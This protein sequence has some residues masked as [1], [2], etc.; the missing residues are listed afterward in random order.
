MG[1]DIKGALTL[2]E[3]GT[4]AKKIKDNTL[5]ILGI[6]F[7]NKLYKMYNYIVYNEDGYDLIILVTR[8]SY[9]LYRIFAFLIETAAQTTDLKSIENN[10]SKIIN[11][12]QLNLL[13]EREYE[14][15][16]NSKVLVVDDILVRGNSIDW[17]LKILQDNGVTSCADVMVYLWDDN[18]NPK[19]LPRECGKLHYYLKQSSNV[20]VEVSSKLIKIILSTIVPYSSYIHG[21][22]RFNKT[23]SEG[24]EEVE[25]NNFSSFEEINNASVNEKR[26]SR[27]FWCQLEELGEIKDFF[28][29][30]TEAA[31][32]RVYSIE[33]VL[34]NKSMLSIVPF[35]FLKQMENWGSNDKDFDSFIQKVL[36]V[37]VCKGSKS[38]EL[39][40][41]V[42]MS[43]GNCNRLKARLFNALLSEFYG[44]FIF[45]KINLNVSDLYLDDRQIEMSFGKDVAESFREINRNANNC[46]YL[47]GV[48]KRWKTISL[49][50]TGLKYYMKGKRDENIRLKNTLQ[51][52]S[53]LSRKRVTTSKEYVEIVK[54]ILCQYFIQNKAYKM[55]YEKK[56]E[57][58]ESLSTQCIV[59]ILTNELKD[60][61]DDISD[62][63]KIMLTYV[64][65]LISWDSG[66]SSGHFS[67][68]NNVLATVHTY[69]EQHLVEAIL[70]Y[71]NTVVGWQNE[72]NLLKCEAMVNQEIAQQYTLKKNDRFKDYEAKLSTNIEKDFLKNNI[73]I[74]ENI[75]IKA[76]K[77]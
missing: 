12:V 7:F 57:H 63:D 35:V 16:K 10:K 5:E 3:R 65:L 13:L 31:F 68:K 74:L 70:K 67:S 30:F 25:M 69:G 4:I 6:G 56:G 40:H 26:D 61:S 45:Q 1:D 15:Y 2:E 47:S 37:L 46:A 41:N 76:L 73:D 22:Y 24:L 77:L 58:L 20:R 27:Y 48:I 62:N 72:L 14:V 43:G 23:I 18:N 21:R 55:D 19:F 32:I 50:E 38:Y 51:E 44:L 9:I 33:N 49:N 42:F 36:N 29:I 34:E 71:K 66:N 28:E 75:D 17:V 60:I 8:R 53:H 64:G 54:D 39:L 59:N 52:I 11:D